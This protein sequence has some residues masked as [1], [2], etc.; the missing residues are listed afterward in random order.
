MMAMKGDFD[1]GRAQ[2]IANEIG[3]ITTRLVFEASKTWSGVYALLNSEQQAKLD[4]L[5][6][7]REAHRGKWRKG[8]AKE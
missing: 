7:Q 6:K 4:E 8:G 2:R 3:E 5:M 1:A